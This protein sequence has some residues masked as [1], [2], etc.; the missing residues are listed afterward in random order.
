MPRDRKL[1]SPDMKRR[2]RILERHNRR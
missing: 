1:T 2:E